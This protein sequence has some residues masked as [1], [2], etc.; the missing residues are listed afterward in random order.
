MRSALCSVGLILSLVSPLPPQIV[1]NEVMRDPGAVPDARGEW[2]ELFNDSDDSADIAGW[3]IADGGQD[4]H[5]I[6]EASPLVV[7]PRDFLVLGR[8]GDPSENGGYEPDY[9]YSG[10]V[11]SNSRD[12]IILFGTDGSVADSIAYDETWPGGQGTSME[13]I[14]PRSDN[15]VPAGWGDAVR[16]YGDGDAGTPGAWNSISGSGLRDGGNGPIVPD[17]FLIHPWPN[18]TTGGVRVEVVA[19]AGAA[20]SPCVLEVFTLRGRL[21]ESVVSGSLREGAPTVLRWNGRTGFGARVPAGIYLLRVS[22]GR[23]S[24][25]EKIVML[26]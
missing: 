25:V 2:F 21:L 9:V 8:N 20:G 12:E 7:G 10:F 11:L 26:R 14:A 23:M 24:A 5:V 6:D 3:V 22:S 1:I 16:P 17:A 19:P 18:P 13:L 15:G 4:R